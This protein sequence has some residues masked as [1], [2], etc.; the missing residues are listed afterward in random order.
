MGV[1]TYN[2]VFGQKAKQGP[3]LF[4]KFINYGIG[5]AKVGMGVAEG[6]S[7]NP[8]GF[9]NAAE[10]FGGMVKDKIDGRIYQ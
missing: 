6:L 9:V 3:N 10:H 7:G 2:D 1:N 8:L 4:Q 5:V